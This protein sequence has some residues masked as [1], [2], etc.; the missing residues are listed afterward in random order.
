MTRVRNT[1][2]R[3][4][5]STDGRRGTCIVPFPHRPGHARCADQRTMHISKPN[6]GHAARQR[7]RE[8][9]H[10]NTKDANQNHQFAM[11]PQRA[12]IHP[13]PAMCMATVGRSSAAGQ[14]PRMNE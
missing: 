7:T 11:Q 6:P 14:A 13:A 4:P 5:S 12:A 2:C 8:H 10:A 1:C 9:G 3:W